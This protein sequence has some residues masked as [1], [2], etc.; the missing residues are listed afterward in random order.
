MEMKLKKNTQKEIKESFT[1]AARRSYLVSA[2][3]VPTGVA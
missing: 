1:K 3:G 2:N